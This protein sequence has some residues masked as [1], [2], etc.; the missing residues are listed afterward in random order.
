MQPHVM[1]IYS[2]FI[3]PS[4]VP[5][6]MAPRISELHQLYVSFLTEKNMSR[7]KTIITSILKISILSN[8]FVLIKMLNILLCLV[9]SRPTEV[10]YFV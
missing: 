1:Q 5:G 8:N 2:I 9:G 10:G 7:S 6:L 4:A 3:I